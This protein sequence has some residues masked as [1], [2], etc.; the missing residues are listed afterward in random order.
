M[1]ARQRSQIHSQHW[2]GRSFGLR[3][4]IW[5]GNGSRNGNVCSRFAAIGRGKLETRIRLVIAPCAR[6]VNDQEEL[7]RF[8]LTDGWL[9]KDNRLGCKLRPIALIPS[10]HE[11]L[12]VYRIDGWI[13]DE[14]RTVGQGVADERESNHRQR[15]LANG[16]P[17]PPTKRTFKYVGRALL[18]AKSFRGEQLDVVWEEPPLGHSNVVGWPTQSGNRKSNEA[19][20]LAKALR[21]IDTN[22]VTYVAA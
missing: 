18:K 1:G 9:Y 17:Y 4:Y 3:R 11:E 7:A 15:E 13:P 22:S 20:Q 14:V 2:R 8:V 10:P 16:K 19:A 21:L 12:S 6:F 5:V